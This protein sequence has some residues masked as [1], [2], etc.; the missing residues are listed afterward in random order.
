VRTEGILTQ[1]IFEHAL[2][3]RMKAATEVA[4]VSGPSTAAPSPDRVS[5]AE[6]EQD[7]SPTGS[8]DS[9]EETLRASSSSLKSA[10]SGGSKGKQTLKASKEGDAATLPVNAGNLVGK[11]NNLVSTDLNNITEA[12]DFMFVG[13]FHSYFS[14]I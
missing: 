9:T 1:L 8:N 11:I 13:E 7:S 4:A 12:R 10:S 3:I 6:D 5:I 14:C 2:R